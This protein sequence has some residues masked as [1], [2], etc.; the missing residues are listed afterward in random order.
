MTGMVSVLTG[1]SIS[2]VVVSSLWSRSFGD[3]SDSGHVRRKVEGNL[4]FPV[5]FSSW[6]GSSGNWSTR[7]SS[8]LEGLEIQVCGMGSRS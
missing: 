1:A 2:F 5:F 6:N 7:N 4:F 8:P 3:D